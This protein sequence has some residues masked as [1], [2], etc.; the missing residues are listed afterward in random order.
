[1]DYVFVGG[2]VLFREQSYFTGDRDYLGAPV[3]AEFSVQAWHLE[4]ATHLLSN[5]P[6]AGWRTKFA[7]TCGRLVVSMLGDMK[8]NLCKNRLA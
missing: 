8:Y 4:R 6:L 7:R 2:G 5:E 3:R 1:M